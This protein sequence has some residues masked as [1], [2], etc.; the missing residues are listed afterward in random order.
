VAGEVILDA[1]CA[2]ADLIESLER[3]IAHDGSVIDGA[4]GQRVAHPAL[5]PLARHRKLLVDLMHQAFPED[6]S[7]RAK[8]A[9]RARWLK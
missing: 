6:R 9:A 5:V 7:E 4:R 3:A 2:E 8:A 1:I